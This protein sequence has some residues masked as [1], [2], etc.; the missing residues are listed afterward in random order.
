MMNERAAR[1]EGLEFTGFYESHYMKTKVKERAAEIRKNYK[2]R[3]VLVDVGS[4]V[5]VYADRSYFN[6]TRLESIEKQLENMPAR[7][8]A[9]YDKY[10]ADLEELCNSEDKLREMKESLENEK[11]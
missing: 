8:Q 9:I 6:Q 10:L 11:Q 2:C 4:G 3:A 7:K 5:S 1:R